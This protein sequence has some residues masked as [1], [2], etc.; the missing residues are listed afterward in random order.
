MSFRSL[1]LDNPQELWQYPTG[2][3][4]TLQSEFL[5]SRAAS[6]ILKPVIEKYGLIKLAQFTHSLQIGLLIFF[7][8][9]PP[10]CLPVYVDM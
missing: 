7:L 2:T 4:N 1:E 6:A 5:G 10:P 3:D 8:S 9:T